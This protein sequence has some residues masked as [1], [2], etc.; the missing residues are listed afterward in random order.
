[1]V[2]TLKIFIA[3]LFAL[4]L[5]AC[6]NKSKPP[7]DILPQEKMQQMMWDMIRADEFAKGFAIKDTTKTLKEHSIILY[8]KVFALHKVSKEI[9]AK[10]LKYYQQDPLRNKRLFDSLSAQVSNYYQNLYK[11][12]GA[13]SARPVRQSSM[14][15]PEK[16]GQQEQKAVAD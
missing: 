2:H 7:V 10:S 12:E 13:D 9:F 4:L 16:Q 1:M 5:H 14:R 8:E 6:K 11:G 3:C 15:P